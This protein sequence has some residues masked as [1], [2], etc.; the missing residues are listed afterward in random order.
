[1][2]ETIPCATQSV[3]DSAPE[4][5]TRLC[6]QRNVEQLRSDEGN[7]NRASILGEAHSGHF[8]ALYVFA[9]IWEDDSRSS[10]AG[11]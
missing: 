7:V 3:R 11:E 9:G 10:K 8:V 1:M 5:T 6:P 2:V 4:V